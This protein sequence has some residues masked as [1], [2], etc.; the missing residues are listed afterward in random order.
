MVFG[1]G[2]EKLRAHV[3][4]V[5]YPHGLGSLVFVTTA[6]EIH[7]TDDVQNFIKHI[8]VTFSVLGIGLSLAVIV[9]MWVALRPM[10]AIRDAIGDIRSGKTKRPRNGRVRY[11]LK[12]PW[13]K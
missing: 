3:V 7:I 4:H 12:T 1:P 9:Q 11:K 2:G 8:L 6:P 5:S 10:K 13:R